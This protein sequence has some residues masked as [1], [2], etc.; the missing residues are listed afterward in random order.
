[1]HSDCFEFFVRDQTLEKALDLLWIATA[2]QHPWRGAPDL[3]L[4]KKTN[5]AL[6]LLP[7]AEKHCIPELSL[8]R[9][10]LI[11]V[12]QK[13]SERYILALD[14]FYWLSTALSNELVSVPLCHISGWQ[15]GDRPTVAVASAGRIVR[16]TIDYHGIRKIERLSKYPIYAGS[17]FNNVAF[18][19]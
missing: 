7:K 17:R 16:L 9:L 12:I 3:R 8:L 2:W 1:M 14:L 18:V 19:I 15:R 11:Q 4:Y 13:Y 10:E 6:K 5:I